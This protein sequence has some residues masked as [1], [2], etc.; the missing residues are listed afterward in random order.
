M[1]D[2]TETPM[3]QAIAE[4]AAHLSGQGRW[5]PLAKAAKLSGIPTWSLRDRLISLNEKAGGGIMR[6]HGPGERAHYDVN[7]DAV[8]AY[9][10]TASHLATS[11]LDQLREQIAASEAKI[12]ALRRMILEL[13]ATLH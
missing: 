13:R 1:V 3:P 8:R 9:H 10:S 11:E 12:D 2:E 7:I 6:K 5:I 4:F